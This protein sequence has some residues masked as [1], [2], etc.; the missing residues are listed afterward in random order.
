MDP[1][2]YGLMLSFYRRYVR[3]TNLSVC[4]VGSYSENGDYR[5]LFKNHKY[6]GLDIIKGPNVDV[7]SDDSYKYPFDHNT[8]DVVISASTMEHVKDIYKWI[9]E[10]KRIVKVGGLIC[11]VAPSHFMHHQHP[12]DCWRIY[13]DGMRFL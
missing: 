13:P 7:V 8:F 3:G 11:V 9:L 1:I 5:A 2:S 4:D 12:V 10:L 6:I